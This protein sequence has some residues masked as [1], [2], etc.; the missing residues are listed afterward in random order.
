MRVIVLV[1]ELMLLCTGR[2]TH[3]T[4]RLRAG[5]VC[6]NVARDGN[7]RVIGISCWN[8]G[9]TRRRA[10]GVVARPDRPLCR[11]AAGDH[12]RCRAGRTRGQS[13]SFNAESMRHVACVLPT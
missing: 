6:G 1:G 8:G 7:V 4:S 10:R 2:D 12:R 11:R 13:R 9:W 5:F 3:P